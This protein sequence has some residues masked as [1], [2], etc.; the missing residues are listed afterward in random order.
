MR[1]ICLFL[2]LCLLVFALPLT[3]SADDTTNLL[4]GAITDWQKGEAKKALIQAD[5]ATQNIW[6]KTPLYI[7]KS[8]FTSGE[9]SAYGV[10]KQRPDNVFSA[11]RAVILAYLEPIGFR[12]FKT[13]D[14]MYKSGFR[15]DMA[16]LD[17]KGNILI[18]KENFAQIN[19]L[20][21]VFNREL[22]LNVTVTIGG[23]PPGEY[24][25]ALRIHDTAKQQTVVRM[26][27]I[28]K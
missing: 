9:A 28:F 20:S 26:P 17:Y 4:K 8:L 23:V 16:L 22:F 12:I 25:L 5:Q 2:A 19:F 18:G 11:K 6:Q 3:A 10:Y 13:P 21:H 15:I 27:V 1:I 24:L 14:G 7:R